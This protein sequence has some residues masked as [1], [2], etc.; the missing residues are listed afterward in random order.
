[1][2]IYSVLLYVPACCCFHVLRPPTG[3]SGVCPQ[4]C[5]V[6]NEESLLRERMKSLC[7]IGLIGLMG[8]SVRP[9]AAVLLLY[10]VVLSAGGVGRTADHRPVSRATK[11]RYDKA[12][13]I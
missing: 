8:R 12:T 9:A 10:I 7:S 1:M 5:K 3:P 2:L 13:M 6:A 4:K 11:S